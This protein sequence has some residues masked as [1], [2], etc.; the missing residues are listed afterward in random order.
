MDFNVKLVMPMMPNFLSIQMPPGRR[1]DGFK[2]GPKISVADLS[3][4]QVEQF[5]SLWGEAFREHV[6]K[7][8]RTKYDQI[9]ERKTTD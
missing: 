9:F 6:A 4:E 1:E 8:R 3:D 5:I 2:E 7:K